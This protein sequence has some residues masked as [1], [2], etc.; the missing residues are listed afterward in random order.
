M[1]KAIFGLVVVGA[2]I[3]LRP[4]LKRCMLRKM[5]QHCQQMAPHCK[6]TASQFGGQDETAASGA[7]AHKMREHCEQKMATEREERGEPV[8]TA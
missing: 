4:I 7:M 6:Q 2:V 5:Q 8:A 1:R 3:A